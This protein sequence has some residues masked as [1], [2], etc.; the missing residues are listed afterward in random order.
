MKA[1]LTASIFLKI[2]KFC[3][4]NLSNFYPGDKP[5]R[6]AEMPREP[7]PTPPKKKVFL[8]LWGIGRE[9]AGRHACKAS[10]A[11]PQLRRAPQH[12]AVGEGRTTGG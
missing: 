7:P 6:Y 3:A 1:S 8:L 12:G 2:V 5:G 9:R 10:V 11:P 4:D